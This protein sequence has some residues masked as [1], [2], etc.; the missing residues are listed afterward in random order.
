MVSD[1]LDLLREAFELYLFG[2][3]ADVFGNFPHVNF[4]DSFPVSFPPMGAVFERSGCVG[5]CSFRTRW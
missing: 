2:I 4:P 1:R 5:G 3:E